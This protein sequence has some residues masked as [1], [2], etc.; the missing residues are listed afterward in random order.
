MNN[1]DKITEIVAQ[2]KDAI[3][4]VEPLIDDYNKCESSISKKLLE[5]AIVKYSK[6]LY[7]ESK[8]DEA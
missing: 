5:A 7:V 4:V 6:Q 3:G 8:Q 1:I 2:L